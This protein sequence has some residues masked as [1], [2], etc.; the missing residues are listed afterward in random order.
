MSDMSS[1][2]HLKE[3]F[4]IY[5]YQNYGFDKVSG[6]VGDKLEEY[7]YCFDC[8]NTRKV[9]VVKGDDPFHIE[10]CGECC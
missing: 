7:N 2:P 9:E 8:D 1:R 6:L 10:G 4:W 3:S 5:Y